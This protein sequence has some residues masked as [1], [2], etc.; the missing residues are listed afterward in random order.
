MW[1]LICHHT[2]SGFGGLPVDLS[3]HNSHGQS[4]GTAFLPDGIAAA[5]GALR[6]QG[7]G[8]VHIP[9]DPDAHAQSVVWQTL[10]GL[11]IEVTARINGYRA[12]PRVMIRGADSFLFCVWN[13]ELIASYHTTKPTWPGANYERIGSVSDGIDYPTYPVYEV[14]FDPWMLSVPYRW[15]Q[16][17]M[18]QVPFNRWVTFG[19]VHNGL[20]TME[21]FADGELVARR[22]GLLSVVP[23]VGG[24]GVFIGT[25]GD[26]T[27]HVLDGDIDEVKVWRLNPHVMDEEFFSRPVDKSVAD[28]WERF[29]RSLAKALDRYPDCRQFIQGG[30]DE[31]LDRMIRLLLAKGPETRERFIKTSQEYRELWRE[32]KLDSPEM[33]KLFVDWCAWLRLVG[34]SFDDDPSLQDLLRSDCLKKV[35]AEC[36]PLDCDPKVAALVQLIIQ[37]C[38]PSSEPNSGK[39]IWQKT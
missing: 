34:I 38:Q 13:R 29:F 17:P 7:G 23:G 1:E 39:K 21:L 35:L 3:D 11:K 12:L 5:S 19:F 26:Y 32:G 18:Y 4:I 31:A 2:Y 6:F 10:T 25:G 24:Q 22:T 14:P 16:R 37:N 8:R 28:C 27:S 9:V 15:Y 36:E 20:D 33:A 30:L